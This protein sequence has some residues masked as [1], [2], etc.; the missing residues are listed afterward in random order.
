MP[1][2]TRRSPAF[3]RHQMQLQEC[4]GIAGSEPG[5]CIVQGPAP[6]HRPGGRKESRAQSLVHALNQEMSEISFS[7]FWVCLFQ[8][9]CQLL[10]LPGEQANTSCWSARIALRSLGSGPIVPSRGGTEGSHLQCLSEITK[11]KHPW[12]PTLRPEVPQCLP[13]LHSCH[14]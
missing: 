11:A 7:F 9:F 8:L 4:S 1:K 14:S 12:I 5:T 13:P 3:H 10:R 2:P 6:A